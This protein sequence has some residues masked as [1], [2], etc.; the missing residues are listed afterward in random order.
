M[1]APIWETTPWVK[2]RV[3]PDRTHTGAGFWVMLNGIKRFDFDPQ[4]RSRPKYEQLRQYFLDEVTAGRLSPGDVLP[5][6]VELAGFFRVARNTVRQALNRLDE[7][8]VIRRVRGKGTFISDQPPSAANSQLDSFALVLPD[9]TGGHCPDLVQ[10][11]V[12]AATELNSHALVNDT[13]NEPDRQAGVFLKLLSSRPAGVA[14]VPTLEPVPPSQIRLLQQAG[15]GVIFCHRAVEGVRAPLLEM[16]FARVMQTAGEAIARQGHR[17]VGLITS[18]LSPTYDIYRDGLRATLSA[19]GAELR[20]EWTYAGEGTSLDM[21]RQEEPLRKFLI[22]VM[23]AKERPTAIV[24]TFD[25]IAEAVY[26]LLQEL[27]LRIPEDVSLVGF[28]GTRRHSAFL[29]RL[30]SVVI[31][32]E[33][34]GGRAYRLLKEIRDGDRPVEDDA[35]ITLPLD[36]YQGQTLAAVKDSAHI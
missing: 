27:G 2:W 34:I 19:A 12:R 1:P 29:R 15:I 9:T 23:S 11:F 25:S 4:A 32:G 8:G 33:E 20:D 7:D 22:S 36:L 26:L 18:I 3:Q 6:E 17:K 30:T 21:H 24:T 28:G 31:D 14:L 10:G 35:R 5:T 16:P 13:L